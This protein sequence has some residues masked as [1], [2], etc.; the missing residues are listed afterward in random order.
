MAQAT[1]PANLHSLLPTFSGDDE[2][3]ISPTDFLDLVNNVKE[4]NGW[5][6]KATARG[7]ALTFRGEAAQW[8]ALIRK[9]SPA[10]LDSW[11]KLEVLFKKRYKATPSKISQ[12]VDPAAA[13]ATLKQKSGDWQ[14]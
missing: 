9:R 4:T 10:D 11:K 5:D 1:I 8:C 14:Y 12:T 7:V 13:L 6:D 3:Q 2:T